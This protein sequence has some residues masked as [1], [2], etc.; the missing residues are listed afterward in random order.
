MQLSDEIIKIAE[1]I[2]SK[3]FPKE[4]NQFIEIIQ[5][6]KSFDDAFKKIHQIKNVPFV[7]SQLFFTLYN[8]S[9]NL[10]I[11]Q[12]FKLFYD[13][14]KTQKIAEE[15]KSYKEPTKKEIDKVVKKV[16]DTLKD[17]QKDFKQIPK[18][19][20]NSTKDEIEGFKMVKK[21]YNDKIKLLTND[22]DYWKS[23][24]KNYK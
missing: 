5:K 8:K 14:V 2:K 10:T 12:A 16:E 6:S 17:F 13:D 1:I 7:T 3:K 9:G 24:Q 18:L 22:L 21:F 23:L 4:L 15:I 11:K 19:P 20:K